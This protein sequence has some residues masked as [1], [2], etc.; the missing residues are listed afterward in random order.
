MQTQ[1]AQL[2]YPAADHVS[3]AASVACLWCSPYSQHV[4]HNLALLSVRQQAMANSVKQLLLLT[5]G[6]TMIDDDFPSMNGHTAAPLLATRTAN[7]PQQAE[8]FPQLSAAAAGTASGSDQD[9][10]SQHRPSR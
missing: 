2:G 4:V 5:G 10:P 3:L 6:M 1:D 7:V 9:Q 8:A